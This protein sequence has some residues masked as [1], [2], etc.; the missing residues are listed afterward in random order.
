VSQNLAMRPDLVKDDFVRNK[1]KVLGCFGLQ[2]AW[3]V[4]IV[5][6]S[7]HHLLRLCYKVATGDFQKSCSRNYIDGKPYKDW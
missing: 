4:M 5:I 1:L 2:G 6:D 7:F 3:A